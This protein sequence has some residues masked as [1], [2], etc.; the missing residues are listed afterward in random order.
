MMKKIYL[1][2]ASIVAPLVLRL[3]YATLRISVIH[4]F[5]FQKLSRD[6]GRFILVFWHENMVLPLY[7][8]RNRHIDVLVSRHF[9]GEIITRILRGFGNSTV[10]GSSTRGGLEAYRQLLQKFNSQKYVAAFTPD[11]PRGPRRKAKSGVVRLA[12]A[13]GV[14]ILPLGV[15]ASH[16]KRLRSWD[17]FLFIKPFSR[18]VLSIGEPIRVSPVLTKTSL[19]KEVKSLEK[20][21]NQL[22]CQ[23]RNYL[24]VSATENED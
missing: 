12:S 2:A 4:P 3:Y 5:Y 8:F 21:L 22:D 10:R 17:R 18:C 24:N 6:P 23:A 9:D 16:Y 13:A 1:F 7:V 19:E 11:G 14:P 15:A 20:V